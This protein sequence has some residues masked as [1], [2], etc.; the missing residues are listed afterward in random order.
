MSAYNAGA[1]LEPAMASILHQTY[2]DFEFLIVND[3]STDGST[4]TLRGYA[5][6]DSRIILV[7][8]TNQGLTASLNRGL[9]MARG[10]YVVRM[11]ADD[12]SR[13]ERLNNV[14]DFFERNPTVD[15]V[16]TGM[17]CFSDGDPGVDC[18]PPWLTHEKIAAQLLFRN[19]IAHPTVAFRRARLSE[20]GLA[21]SPEFVHAEDY[22]LW[23]RAS[24]TLL[25]C[26]LPKVTVDRRVHN[27]SV[28]QNSYD[29]MCATACRVSHR[30]LARLQLRSAEDQLTQAAIHQSGRGPEPQ[31][32]VVKA[33]HLLARIE[34]R[35]LASNIYTPVALRAVLSRELCRLVE[36]PRGHSVRDAMIIFASPLFN[37]KYWTKKQC[38]R[39]LF[40]ACRRGSRPAEQ[41]GDSNI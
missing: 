35:N 6:R 22:E 9:G 32:G 34:Q 13:P 30:A 8:Q 41:S 20:T 3:G 10:K 24:G 31:V 26:N 39:L 17:H 29:E 4:E 38:A 16:G 2:R 11:D 12:V 25:L 33:V 27:K 21:Y 18:L 28:T 15:L 23:E 14:C 1:Y 36:W 5:A 40:H 19:S 7:E 37:A